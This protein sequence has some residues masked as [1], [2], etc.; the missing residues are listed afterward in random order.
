[1]ST[2]QNEIFCVLQTKEVDVVLWN[3]WLKSIRNFTMNVDK[4]YITF[5]HLTN[6]I[7]LRDIN[8]KHLS[9]SLNLDQ[10]QQ[11]NHIEIMEMF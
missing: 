4:K 7:M 3:S 1:M 5:E 9:L 2:P 10:N 6:K 11:Q 8:S